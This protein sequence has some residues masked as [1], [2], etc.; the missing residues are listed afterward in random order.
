[1]MSQRYLKLCSFL[2]LF[3]LTL[4]NIN[5]PIF[6]FMD[7]FSTDCSKLLLDLFG[8]ILPLAIVL[9][10]FRISTWYLFETSVCWYS[11]LVHTSFSLFPLSSFPMVPF[12]S[13]S[14]FKTTDLKSIVKCNVWAFLYLFFLWNGSYIVLWKQNL[15]LKTIEKWHFAYDNVV[16]LEITFFLFSA[17]AW[18]GCSYFSD[19]SKFFLKILYSL[20]SMVT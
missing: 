12:K 11:L 9:F 13:L 14:T 10:S 15:L 6:K 4:D 2:I 5:W 1:M 16:T 18:V 17:V 8:E 7:S 19:F 3:S 20:S